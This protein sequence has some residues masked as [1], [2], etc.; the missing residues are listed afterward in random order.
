MGRRGWVTEKCY[1]NNSQVTNVR[2]TERNFSLREKG[3]GKEEET[4]EEGGGGE[5]MDCVSLVFVVY[6]TDRQ[7]H[8]Y[9][10]RRLADS[11]MLDIYQ[12]QH[13]HR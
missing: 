2:E 10:H 6:A 13:K 7:K 12:Q 9:R 11:H 3:G 5:V 1:H 8:I 4:E